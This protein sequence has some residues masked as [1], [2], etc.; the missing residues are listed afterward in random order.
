MEI[1]LSLNF[2]LLSLKDP[3]CARDWHQW[4]SD[5]VADLLSALLYNRMKK[6]LNILSKFAVSQKLFLRTRKRKLYVVILEIVYQRIHHWWCNQ[7]MLKQ[8]LYWNY[9]LLL[10][11]IIPYDMRL[12]LLLDDK[13]CF[14]LLHYFR[15]LLLDV[16]DYN[17]HIR[18]GY[19]WIMVNKDIHHSITLFPLWDPFYYGLFG[20]CATSKYHL[21]FRLLPPKQLNPKMFGYLF[22]L[23]KLTNVFLCSLYLH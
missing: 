19:N 4:L 5:W 10:D 2:E 16:F 13:S 7:V 6:N 17:P 21:H 14:T 20:I 18:V 8:A 3:N 15:R 11:G 1:L 22:A 12:S 23:K 9:H